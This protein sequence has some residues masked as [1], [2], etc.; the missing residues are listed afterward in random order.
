MPAQPAIARVAR[1]AAAIALLL[2]AAGPVA[3]Q[4]VAPR[5]RSWELR[6]PSGAL[7]A[8]GSQR[9]HLKDAHLTALQLSWVVRP[10]IALNTTVSWARSRD[11]ASLGQPKVNV[12]SSDVGV[13]ARSREWFTAAPVS[14]STFAGFGAG[15]R[16]YHPANDEVR[17]NA[18]GYASIGG[19]LGRGRVALRVEARNYVTAFTPFA[20][21]GKAEAR[22]DVIIMAAFRF[23][24][25]PS[26]AR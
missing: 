20:S 17:N 5:T 15:A 18:A 22:N 23:N 8:T 16:S 12:F 25:R 2:S 13:E 3:A 6:V 1:P 10:G 4:D 14:L 11:L 21:G 7:V 9:E 26:E 24:R 19:E